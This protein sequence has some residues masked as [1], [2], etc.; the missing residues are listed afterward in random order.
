MFPEFD[1][2][3]IMRLSEMLKDTHKE[4]LL[5]DILTEQLVLGKRFL[6]ANFS[7]QHKNHHIHKTSL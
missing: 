2:L 7:A 5:H 4:K 6:K 1:H 3:Q